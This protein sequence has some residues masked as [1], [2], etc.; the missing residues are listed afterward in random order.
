MRPIDPGLVLVGR[1]AVTVDAIMAAVMGYDP[2]ASTKKDVW[3]GYNHLELL[4]RAGVATNDPARIEVL[5]T[6]LADALHDFFPD[7]NGWVKRNLVEKG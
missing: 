3:I 4:A 6:P 5:G 7:L 1:N 2:T